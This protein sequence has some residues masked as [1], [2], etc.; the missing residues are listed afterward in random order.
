MLAQKIVGIKGRICVDS[1]KGDVECDWDPGFSGWEQW[2]L[3]GKINGA[4]KKA[5]I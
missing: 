2:W 5:Y 4:K 1:I 3:V